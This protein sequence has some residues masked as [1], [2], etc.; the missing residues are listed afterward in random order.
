[1]SL[2]ESFGVSW[3]QRKRSFRSI[4]LW[5][6]RGK[7]RLKGLA[8]S[9]CSKRKSLQVREHNLL[10]DLAAHLK[11][12]IDCGSVSFMEVYENVLARIVGFDRLKAEG[13][14]VRARVQWA[15][16]GEMSSRYFLRL[17]KKQGANQWIAAM[18]GAD[19]VVL[20]Y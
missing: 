4:Q 2:V 17:E 1:M 11:A 9:F 15:E 19:G 8:I 13:T 7:E 14:H 18:R 10:V 5:W 6:D 20:R 3:R 16:E 12:K